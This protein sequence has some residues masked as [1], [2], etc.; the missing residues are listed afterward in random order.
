[1][2]TGGILFFG[3]IVL[4]VLGGLG[5]LV[6]IGPLLRGQGGTFSNLLAVLVL[7]AL[8]AAAG[9]LLMAA[10]SRRAKLER[11]NEDRGFTELATS[12]ARKNGGRVGLDQVARASG[13]PSGDAQAKMRQLTGRGLFELDFDANGQ[14]VFK[15]SPDAGRAQLAE[16]GGRT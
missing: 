16:L 8:P 12:L 11:E 9:V 7:G 10:G 1:M 15:L 5:G 3:G 4:L 14:M 2:K 6:F 13:L